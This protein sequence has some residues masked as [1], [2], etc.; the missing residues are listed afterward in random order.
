MK[1]AKSRLA[2]VA[3]AAV[4]AL[5]VTVTA[6]VPAHAAEKPKTKVKIT[7]IKSSKA[8][9]TVSSK[10]RR[11]EKARK[12]KLYLIDEYTNIRVGKAKTKRS[13]K[14]KVKESLE[15]GRYYAKAK[16]KKIRV[17]GKKVTCKAD[18]SPTARLR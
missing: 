10:V 17:H 16:K 6:A 11:C 8:K 15:P 18:E 9:G 3:L 2:R 14:W 12:V 13:G 5:A 7:K 4:A 1:Q